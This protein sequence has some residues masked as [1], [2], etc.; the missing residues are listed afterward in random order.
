MLFLLDFHPV[1]LLAFGNVSLDSFCSDYADCAVE[2]SDALEFFAV[3][4]VYEKFL[5]P[6]AHHSA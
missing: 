3:E 1:F 5:V 4:F 2:V 6:F